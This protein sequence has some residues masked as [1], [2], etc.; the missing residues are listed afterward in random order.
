MADDIRIQSPTLR[1]PYTDKRLL[2][3]VERISE[4]LFGL[5]MALT[6]TGTLSVVEA[7]RAEVKSML[8]GAIGCNI[9]WGLV[10]AVMYL[11]TTM[12]TKGRQMTILEFVKGTKESEKAN[13]Y[14]AEQLPPVVTSVLGKKGLDEIR[15]KLISLPQAPDNKLNIRDFIRS[16]YI[17]LLVVLSTF[18]AV[19]PFIFVKEAALAL[20][21]SNVVAIV[22]MFIC[23][24]I[25][26]S[27]A[28][29]NKFLTGI[30]MALLGTA[31]VFITIL[32]GG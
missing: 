32:L 16:L 29:H 12:V 22:M 18:P 2:D 25:L 20:R 27:Y 3:P 26:A 17:F 19:I 13:K 23:G 14:I 11:V 8:I 4:I 6:F 21:I 9:A 5:I 10:D 24:W 1:E 7:D 28:G 15:Q 30:I 31:L